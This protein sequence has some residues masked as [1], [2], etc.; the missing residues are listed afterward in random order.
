MVWTERP[1]STAFSGSIRA[2]PKAG[3]TIVT[4][5]ANAASPRVVASIGGSDLIYADGVI[6]FLPASVSGIYRRSAAGSITTLVAGVAGPGPIAVDAANV[7]VS[8]GW[9]IKRV[10]RTGGAASLVSQGNFYVTSLDVD[11]TNVYWVEDDLGNVRRAPLAGGAS[12]LVGSGNGKPFDLRVSGA[13]VYWLLGLDR[14]LKVPTAGGAVAT[15]A[16]SLRAA[17]ALAV[18][19][20]YAYFTESDAS[21]VSKAP[22]TGGVVAPIGDIEGG[23]AWYALTQD[24]SRIF[25]LTPLGLGSVAKD[26]TSSATILGAPLSDVGVRGSIAVDDAYVYW[27]ETLIGAIKRAPK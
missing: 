4:L 27:A 7:Y 23:Q 15:V 14:L 22:I 17:E 21:S 10:P 13:S 6:D 11:S 9:W 3:G 24:A 12:T 19:A 20:D 5:I 1:G 2:V 8:E 26:G 16:G 18:D 25:W